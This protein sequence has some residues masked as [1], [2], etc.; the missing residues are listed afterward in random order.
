M[1]WIY[2]YRG[3]LFYRKRVLVD[4]PPKMI[5]SQEIDE[6]AFVNLGHAKDFISNDEAKSGILNK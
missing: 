1:I 4:K 3:L 6:N 2:I 5:G